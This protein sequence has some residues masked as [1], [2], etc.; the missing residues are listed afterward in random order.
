M[1]F[2]RKRAWIASCLAI[3]TLA[4]TGIRSER[5]FAQRR[6]RGEVASNS[7]I[8][9]EVRDAGKRQAVCNDG[10]AGRVLFP[11][12]SRSRPPQMDRLSAGWRRLRD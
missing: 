6:G 9:H 4:A 8:K 2:E 10:L 1:K 11:A 12:R 7:A 5:A 3:A